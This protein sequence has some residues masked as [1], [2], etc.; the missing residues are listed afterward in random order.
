VFLLDVSHPEVNVTHLVAEG[1]LAV[2]SI[3]ASVLHVKRRAPKPALVEGED[4]DALRLPVAVCV[5]MSSDV[6]QEA[7]DEDDRRA[8][9][10]RRRVRAGVELMSSGTR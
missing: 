7:M 2:S 8:S 3:L 5:R 10:S 4:S 6:V 9:R 1:L